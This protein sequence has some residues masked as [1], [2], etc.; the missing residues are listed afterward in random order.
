MSI[1]DSKTGPVAVLPLKADKPIRVTITTT[2]SQLGEL[3]GA[4]PALRPTVELPRVVQDQLAE[5]T[6]RPIVVLP[7]RPRLRETAGFNL[8][9]GLTGAALALLLALAVRREQLP[10]VAQPCYDAATG[11]VR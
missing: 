11:A 3:L 10:V 2:K 8:V 4:V 9:C 1:H 6:Q 5:L 7:R